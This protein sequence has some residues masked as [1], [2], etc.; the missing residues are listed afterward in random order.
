MTSLNII[1]RA[2]AEYSE[3]KTIKTL[4][5][6]ATATSIRAAEGLSDECVALESQMLEGKRSLK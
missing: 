2:R 1:R 4:V 5:A 3:S 6:S